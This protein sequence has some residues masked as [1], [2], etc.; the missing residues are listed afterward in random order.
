[1]LL[2]HAGVPG[3]P[4]GFVGV[5]VF[6]VISGFL[7]TGLLLRELGSD[8]PV[9]LAA[10]LR[11]PRAPAAARGLAR[12][13]RD[14]RRVGR[15]L[16]S[17][18]R[19]PAGRGRWR[20]R[21]RCTS[22]TTASRS[23]ATDYLAAGSRPIAAPA[24]LVARRRGAVLPALA[25]AGPRWRR[26]C[27]GRAA[28]RRGARAVVA[29]A[30]FAALDRRGPISRSRGRSS[31]CPPAP[32]SSR[33]RR[34]ARRSARLARVALA[35]G[36]SLAASRLA[37]TRLDPRVR[38]PRS[39]PRRR[40]PGTAAL[41]PV[42]GCRA[43]HRRRGESRRR[44]LAR[45]A[46]ARACR[47]GSGRIS[48][49]LYLWHWPLLILVPIADRTRRPGGQLADRAGCHRSRRP[50]H[51]LDRGAVPRGPRA[52]TRPSRSILAAAGA[53]ACVAVI[54][55]SVGGRLTVGANG[56]SETAVI[57]LP[58]LAP[59]PTLRPRSTPAAGPSA[60]V[61]ATR[62]RADLGSAAGIT[63]PLV[64]GES[65]P[66][67]L[68]R[69]PS[70]RRLRPGWSPALRS[71]GQTSPP[72]VTSSPR[73]ATFLAPDRR[74]LTRRSLSR[75]RRLR[76]VAGTTSPTDH[77]IGPHRSRHRAPC[78]R[79]GHPRHSPLGLP[80]LGPPLASL[81]P[82]RRHRSEPSAHHAAAG[83]CPTRSFPD[84]CRGTWFRRWSTLPTDLPESYSRRLPP[85]FRYDRIRRRASTATANRRRRRSCSATRTRR[86]GCRRCNGSRR[87]TTGG[88]SRSPSRDVRR[89]RVTVWNAPLNRPYRE[90]D[91]WRQ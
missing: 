33:R 34:P 91:P 2:F 69:P 28:C 24:L 56:G 57:D 8:G 46:L 26:G 50:Q 51:A 21:C 31:R 1:M 12:D 7:I 54:A 19:F 87:P 85:R 17:Q 35:D 36:R 60:G 15:W 5:D 62:A 30:S 70:R 48:Y 78:P 27:L 77:P 79:L 40:F 71:S 55:L 53:S 20:G 61:V 38:V 83:R 45:R 58:S 14:A 6:Y 22:R 89:C 11:A 9:D 47:D 49:S 41:M 66:E 90:C 81:R 65:L 74:S 18:L 72:S 86:S 42:A 52:Q 43:A 67:R 23:S 37:R 64:L 59:L 13:R 4:G 29:V 84:R 32:G 10:L 44:S 39:T 80:H 63:P 73:S 75:L 25:A 82:R 3:L 88:L 68:L 76:A 16:L